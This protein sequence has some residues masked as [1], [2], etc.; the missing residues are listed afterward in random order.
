MLDES[1]LVSAL[2]WFVRGFSDRSLIKV[3][4]I[5]RTNIGRLSTDVETALYRVVQE[6]LT[7]IHRHSDSSTAR[8]EL[9]REPKKIILT[10][11]DK[12]KGLPP[13]FLDSKA[14]IQSFGVGIPGMRERLHLL[15]GHL[16][17]RSNSKG[18]TIKATV[19]LTEK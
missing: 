5:E 17:I 16:D 14:G 7:N 4:L 9:K 1:G 12:G 13:G 8:I 19:P 15:G 3:E 10:I 11:K 18:T 2:R 6:S